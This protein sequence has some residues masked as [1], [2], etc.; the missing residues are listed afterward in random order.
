MFRKFAHLWHPL[1]IQI[2]F[3]LERV[4][5]GTAVRVDR[6]ERVDFQKEVP[7]TRVRGGPL[8]VAGPARKAALSGLE[9][10]WPLIVAHAVAC[11]L[12]SS[13]HRAGRPLRSTWLA[14]RHDLVVEI[15]AA[16]AA[17]VVVV[18]VLVRPLPRGQRLLW[19][20]WNP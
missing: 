8:G 2:G 16:A 15:A 9:G 3:G 7:Q 14:A 11:E 17:A 5:E 13:D 19:F 1:F 10:Q 18:V 12:H 6:R 20:S 4:W